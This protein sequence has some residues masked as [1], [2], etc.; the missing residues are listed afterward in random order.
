MANGDVNLWVLSYQV[1][2][3]KELCDAPAQYKNYRYGQCVVYFTKVE[4]KILDL[5]TINKL[6]STAVNDMF[7][8]I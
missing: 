7:T 2:N 1:N 3:S 8:M 4:G 6:Q 5:F